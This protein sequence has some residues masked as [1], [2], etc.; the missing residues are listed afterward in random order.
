MRFWEAVII[1]KLSSIFLCQMFF[2]RLT[3]PRKID[4]LFDVRPAYIL[5]ICT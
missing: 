2:L 5:N 4:A 1:S 3:F